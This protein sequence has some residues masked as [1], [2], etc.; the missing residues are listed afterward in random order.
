M[1]LSQAWAS[2]SK[3]QLQ[4]RKLNALHTTNFLSEIHH[5]IQSKRNLFINQKNVSQTKIINTNLIDTLRN[6]QHKNASKSILPI[7]IVCNVIRRFSS[8]N[9]NRNGSNSKVF[10]WITN[11]FSGNKPRGNFHTFFSSIVISRR[12]LFVSIF[13]STKIIDTNR[14][15]TLSFT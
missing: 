7:Q 4:G 1:S 8:L 5:T 9:S 13:Q 14:L 6:L 11:N 2:V 10:S 3:T 15:G 12:H